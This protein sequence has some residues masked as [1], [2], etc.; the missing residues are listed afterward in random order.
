MSAD[1]RAAYPVPMS[2][3]PD[4]L[5]APAVALCGAVIGLVCAWL[6]RTSPPKP[7]NL[8]DGRRVLHPIYVEPTPWWVYAVFATLG[9]VMALLALRAVIALRQR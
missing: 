9:V 5:R 7:L 6:T 2:L 1:E 8:A 4:A 3:A